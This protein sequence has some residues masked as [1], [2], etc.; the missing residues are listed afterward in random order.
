VDNKTD[1][2]PGAASFFREPGMH[3]EPTTVIIPLE[4]D[5]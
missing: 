4:E 3:E 2:V 5:G 1:R